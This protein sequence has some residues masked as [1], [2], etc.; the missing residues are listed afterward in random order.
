METNS[1][2]IIIHYYISE[3]RN[4]IWNSHRESDNISVWGVGVMILNIHVLVVASF[5][6]LRTV[7]LLLQSCVQPCLFIIPEPS[8]EV[9]ECK[10]LGP[11]SSMV[12]GS[13]LLGCDAVLLAE[14]ATF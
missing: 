2:S 3:M 4:Q 11:Y 13:G 10:I 6:C 9:V 14:L 1:H 8:D 12:E 7:L 5:T